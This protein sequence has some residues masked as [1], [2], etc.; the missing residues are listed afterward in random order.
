MEF[1][2]PQP[3]FMQIVDY[4]CDKVLR[5][6]LVA[7]GQV[8]SVREL[9]VAL[10]VNPNTVMRAVERLAAAGIIYNRRGVGYYVADDAL[11][12]VQ[13]FRRQRLIE[14]RLPQ[15]AAEMNLLD[16]SLEEVTTTLRRLLSPRDTQ[17]P[18]QEHTVTS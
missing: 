8:P 6:E 1:Q 11:T 4:V 13:A 7:A 5:R 16:M 10:Q 17:S 14:T 3:I 12:R 9:A 15:I 2:A 18:A